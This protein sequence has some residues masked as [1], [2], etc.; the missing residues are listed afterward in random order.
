MSKS[1]NKE[2]KKKKLSKNIWC[3]NHLFDII[4][5]Y[6]ETKCSDKEE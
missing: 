5:Y 3:F 6:L 2:K 1:F 4:Q